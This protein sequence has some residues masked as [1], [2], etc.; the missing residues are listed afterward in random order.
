ML[1]HLFFLS[2]IFYLFTFRERGR[3]GER[4]GEKWERNCERYIN[5]WPLTCPQTGTRPANQAYALTTDCSVHR[6]ALNPLSHTN[7]SYFFFLKLYWLCYYSGP[8]FSPLP[9]S[10][11]HPLLPE[12]ILPTLFMSMGHVCKFWLLHFL[13]CTVHPHGY[14]I[15]TCLYFLIPSPLHPFPH[16]PPSNWPHQNILCICDSVSVLLVCLVCFLDSI[17][18]RYVFIA[19][20]TVHIFDF[21]LK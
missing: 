13:Y 11:Q 1:C 5:Q 15:S 7:Q 9:P 12:A 2:K 3:E 21:F 17:V 20:I 10:T 8:D 4:E 19:I 6:L 16:I 14:S 18:D